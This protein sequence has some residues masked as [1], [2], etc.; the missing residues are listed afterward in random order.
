MKID[1]IYQRFFVPQNLREHMSGV[2]GVVSVININWNGQLL[3]WDLLKK[4]SLLHD[5]G[6]IVKFKLAE[7]EMYLKDMAIIL[8]K[9][10]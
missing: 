4:L 1:E 10:L 3:D 8:L 9:P 7:E 2:F 6:N 5:L